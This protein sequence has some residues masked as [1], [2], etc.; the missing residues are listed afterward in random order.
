MQRFL[1][2]ALVPGAMALAAAAHPFAARA[3]EPNYAAW[4][5][6]LA[7]YYDPA[8]GMDYGGLQAHDRVELQGLRSSLARVD[9]ATLGHDERLAFWLNLYN[10]NVVARVV[11]GYPVRSIRD[12]SS[13][14]II[15]LNV[16]SKDT[17]PFGDGTISLDTIENVQ[18]RDGFHDPRIH[19]AINCAAKSCPPLRSEAFVGARVGEQL[20]DQ[21]RRFLAGP[22]LR[23]ERYGKR[24]T[25]HASKILDWFAAD[26]RKWGGGVLPFLR[27]YMPPQKARLLPPDDAIALDYDDYDWS[28][29]DWRRR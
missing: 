3:A 12:L 9:V 26:F 20:D 2:S 11:D 25:V 17:V 14:P 19:F 4:T 27:R 24:A 28:L 22:A 5:R 7:G 16:F 15:R 29:N 21:V 8:R 10:V 23:I 6:L 13:D 18:L 1:R